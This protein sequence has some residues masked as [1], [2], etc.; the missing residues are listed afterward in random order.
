MDYVAILKRA[1]Q[2]TWQNKALWLFGILLAFFGG[3]SR[4]GGGGNFGNWQG[5]SSNGTFSNSSNWNFPT[6]DTGMIIAIVVVLLIFFFALM[7]LG[8][9]VRSVTRASLIGMVEKIE[10]NIPVSIKDGWRIGWSGKAWRIFGVNIVIGVPMFIISMGTLLIVIAPMLL[11]FTDDSLLPFAIILVI[12]FLLG[13]IIFMMLLT[14]V[15]SPVTELSW[16]VAVLSEEGVWGSIK[17]SLSLIRHAIKDVALMLLI[18][19]GVGIAWGVFNFVFVL[20]LLA[21]GILT[22]GIPAL[23]GYFLTQEPMVAMLAGLPV[24]LAV[25]I[26]PLTFVGGVFLV[27]HSTVWTL[28]YRELRAVKVTDTPTLEAP[29]SP[30]ETET[31]ASDEDSSPVVELDEPESST[32]DDASDTATEPSA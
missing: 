32:L 25:L 8:I 18:L 11:L 30:A 17:H 13:W 16:R 5:S 31:E 26:I 29:S 6:I 2:I 14:A 27:F 4:S 23:I 10:D 1:A 12:L 3:G 21:L 9:I 24:F 15:I 19:F 22:G 7:L 28:F 20:I